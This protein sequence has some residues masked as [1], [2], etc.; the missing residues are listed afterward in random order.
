MSKILLECANKHKSVL[1]NPKPFVRFENFGD[2]SL[3]FSIYFWSN[4]IFPI[5]NVKSDIRFAI[6]KAFKENKVSIPFPQR[7]MHMANKPEKE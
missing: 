5:E 4:R 6:N 3:D 2:S 1:T 7:V